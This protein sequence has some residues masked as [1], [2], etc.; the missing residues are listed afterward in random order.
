[1]LHTT[2]NKKD[3]A[4]TF[5][6]DEI[7]EEDGL[8]PAWSSKPGKW[9][10][11]DKSN[12]GGRH[13]YDHSEDLAAIRS[14]LQPGDQFILD[15]P[16]E[17]EWVWGKGS[18]GFWGKG[19]ALILCA[20]NGVG[21]T[22][23]AG[24]LLEYRTGMTAGNLLGYPVAPGEKRRVLYLAMD[25]PQQARR[26][27]ARLFTEDQRAELRKHMVFWNGPPLRDLAKHPDLLAMYAEAADAD[28]VI[29][30]SLKDAAV[31]LA[32][33]ETG[34]GWN[35][36]RQTCIA[37]GVEL[38]ELHHPVKARSDPPKLEDVFGSM[39]IT[40]GAGSVLFLDGA[41]GDLI[42]SAYHLKPNAEVIDP[43]EISHDPATGRSR[44]KN[45]V[46]LFDLGKRSSGITAQAAAALIHAPHEPGRND[47]E[48][49]R[50]QLDKFVRDGVMVKK[51]GTR[52]GKN[53]GQAASYFV[54]Q[55]SGSS[56]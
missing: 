4:M 21:K 7:E 39:W 20:P 46:D 19:E 27:L 47:L 33:E 31:K 22:T 29:V 48:K 12:S 6:F 40:G 10:A 26:S 9:P 23:I 17:V 36:A 41:A 56:G 55:I 24:Q 18:R 30:D 34:G 49:V 14:R 53:G 5:A 15:A 2:T 54:M 50:R 45:G 42:V 11:D 52:G 37:S 3:T 32:E 28:T 25:R 44:L 51:D 16:S 38:L 35:R 43:F 1:M 8:L 13:R